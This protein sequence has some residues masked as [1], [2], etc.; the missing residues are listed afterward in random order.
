MFAPVSGES[1][2]AYIVV[3]NRNGNESVEIARGEIISGEAKNSFTDVTVP[4]TYTDNNLKATHIYTVFVSS[5]ASTPTVLS[6]QGSK[7]ALNG[8]SD[9]KYVGSVLTVD[10]IVLNY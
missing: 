3:E 5:T 4:L 10:D 8:Y 1:F 6:V 7:N 9:S 2:K